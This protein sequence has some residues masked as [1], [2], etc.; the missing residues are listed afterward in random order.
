MK[1]IRKTIGF[2]YFTT[3]L[4]SCGRVP[5]ELHTV[6]INGLD[7]LYSVR[8]P[9]DGKPVVLM[10]GNGG[11]HKSMVTQ[12]LQLAKAGYRV[13]CPDTRG[14]GANAPL[15]EYHYADFAEDC[16]C[17]IKTLGLEKPVV[18][19]WSDGG[20]NALL[21]ELA[22]P[23]TS[24][25]IVAAGANLY[26]D[27]GEGFEEFKSWILEQGTP[28]VMMMLNEPDIN[29]RDLSAITCPALVT[30]GSKDLISVEHT[31]LISDNIPDAELTVFE[32]ANHG[33]YIKKNPRLGRRMLEFMRSRG[34]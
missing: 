10:H 19:G 9:V 33:S 34:Y 32:G 15:D 16:Y 27:C 20:I 31:K 8:G 5:E 29:P 2:F 22:H 13:Y 6:R 11:S 23:G 12:Q 17:F 4:L 3:L 25:M 21:L 26:P 7:I 14:Q 30:V 28:L 1:I 24:S 18:G